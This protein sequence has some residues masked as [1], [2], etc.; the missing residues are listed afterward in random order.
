MPGDLT[1]DRP[2]AREIF[3]SGREHHPDCSGLTEEAF[4]HTF[5][6]QRIV[7]PESI[8]KDPSLDLVFTNMAP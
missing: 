4:W 2:E 5:Q 7:T 8:A 3:L 6:T 1:I